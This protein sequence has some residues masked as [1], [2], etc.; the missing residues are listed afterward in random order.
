MPFT[1]LRVKGLS[2]FIHAPD[3]DEPNTDNSLVGYE[4]LNLTTT[5]DVQ[6]PMLFSIITMRNEEL[7]DNVGELETAVD[8]KG[9]W[10]T[11]KIGIRAYDHGIPQ[12]CS[13]EIYSIIVEPYNFHDPVFVFPIE[14]TVLR[15]ATERAELNSLLVKVNGQFLDRITATDEDGLEA[16]IVTF[17]VIG[18]DDAVE[19]LYILNDR[20]NQGILMLKKSFSENTR[21]FLV[22]I[23]GTD[24][25]KTPG[26]RHTDISVRVVFVPTQVDPVFPV[27][28]TTVAFV[29]REGGL[30]ETQQLVLAE[31]PKNYLC[32]DDCHDIFYRIL[33]GNDE[34]HFE[35]DSALNT[36]RVVRELNRA[37]SQQHTL[38]IAASNSATANVALQSSILTVIVNVREANPQPYFDRK[39]YT[40]GISTMDSINRV[41][42]TVSAQHSE[43]API[44]YSIDWESMVA[45]PSLA[46]VQQS[47][48]NLQPGSGVLTLNMQPTASMHG[49]FQFDVRATDPAGAYD[50]AEIEGKV[51]FISS[52]FSVGFQMTCNID[53]VLPAA[54]EDNIARPDRTEVRAHF[55]RDQEPVSTDVIDTIRSDSQL[56]TS[57]QRTLSTELLVLQD[58]VTGDIPSI[59]A[60]TS[61]LMVLVLGALAAALAL[62]CLLLLAA[63]VYRTRKLNRQLLALSMTKYGSADSGLNRLGLAAPGTNKHAEAGSNPVWNEALKA[64]DFDALSEDS[65]DSDLIGIEDLPQFSADFLPPEAA[66][67]Q[68]FGKH[69]PGDDIIATH[70]NNFGLNSPPFSQQFPDNSFR[71]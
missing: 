33:D 51:D 24:G 59:S 45:D 48:F 50:T 71:R 66:N 3:R 42:L 8:L 18:D 46:T 30:K 1:T 2:P 5:R 52:T 13:E 55:L 6:H 12:Q 28:T 4:I 62:L 65:D 19:H 41:I 67:T 23:R 60:D 70:K 37:V 40:G 56:L 25:G 15:F 63:F 64:P 34:G 61:A 21:E 26:P 27:D 32:N 22:T 54:D 39:L 31:D 58:L 35:L 53:Q 49:A 43:N 57:I 16:G 17:E 69:Q 14:E 11:Y 10:G 20:E 44:T 9:Y 47:A 38:R 36:L 29:E 7:E 68:K